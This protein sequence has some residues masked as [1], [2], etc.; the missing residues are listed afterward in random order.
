[1]HNDALISLRCRPREDLAAMAV[2][3]QAN[4]VQLQFAANKRFHAE[5]PK[6]ASPGAVVSFREALIGWRDIKNYPEAALLL[7]IREVWGQHC[8]FCWAFFGRDPYQPPAFAR[9]APE[10]QMRCP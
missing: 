5:P 9:M 7:R 6:L 2:V 1:M 3:T 4:L 8:L 10:D